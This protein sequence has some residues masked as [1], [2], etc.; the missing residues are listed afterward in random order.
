MRQWELLRRL[1]GAGHAVSVVAPVT[2]E[3]DAAAGALPAAGI[4]LH[5][6]RR[7]SS[8]ERETLRALARRPGLVPAG[9][10]LPLLAWQVAVFWAALRPVARRLLA[11][12]AFDVVSVEHDYAA[13]WLADLPGHPPALLTLQNV[14]WDQERRRAA[15]VHDLRRRF[16]EWDAERH[17][18]LARV[19]WPAYDALVAVS[20]RDRDLAAPFVP[21]AVTVVPNGA[22]LTALTPAPD[23]PP[24]P[25]TLIFTATMNYG[26]N[27]DGIAWFAAEVWPR[28]RAGAPAAELLVV[29]REP[30]PAVRALAVRPGVT[31]T[32]EVPDVRPYF[33]RAHLAIAP[34]R[35]GG[36]TRLKVVEALAAGRP[37]VSTTLGA[38]GLELGDEVVLRADDAEAFAAGVLALLADPEGR[39]RRAAAGR[40]A[41][42]ARYGWERSAARFRDVLEGL[43]AAP[44]AH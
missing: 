13:P 29:G 15:L 4:A 2:A 32:G 20:E 22:D 11:T 3:Q 37:V 38:E 42:E 16:R 31:V 43:A 17:V 39:A 26:P 23:P 18:R 44:A 40:A 1:P 5:G 24:D 12:G 33:A 35:T 19:T 36:G 14:S 7:P 10:R 28:V 41:V 21:A 27:A 25:P 6:V 8:R 30:P 9:V 34:L